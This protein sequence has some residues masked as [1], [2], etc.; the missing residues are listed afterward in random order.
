MSVNTDISIFGFYGF[1]K[2]IDGY[3][4]KNINKAKIIQNSWKHLEKLQKNDK[5]N[6]NKHVK[7]IF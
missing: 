6:K 3:L 1:I 2:N 5:I 7:V 4:N